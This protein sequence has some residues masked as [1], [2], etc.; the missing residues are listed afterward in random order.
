MN[1]LIRFKQVLYANWLLFFGL[2]LL[3]LLLFKN[4]F[5]GQNIIS[6]F[7]PLPDVVYYLYPAKS[8]IDGA[9]MKVIYND[10][11]LTPITPPLYT[12]IIAP[13][14]IFFNDLR[15]FY[16]INLGLVLT[17]TIFFYQIISK[18]F[19]NLA[20]K[21]IV[22]LTFIST[23]IIYWYPSFSM[24]ENLLICLFIISLWLLLKPLSGLSV[25]AAGTII[26]SFFATKYIAWPLSVSLGLF[27]FL[28]IIN[29]QK[30]DSLKVKLLM[31]LLLSTFASFLLY[32][33]LEFSTK[34]ADVWVVVLENL[35]TV[36]SAATGGRIE[37][38]DDITSQ[39]LMTNYISTLNGS[40]MYSLGDYQ[41]KFFR[42][43]AGLMGGQTP[44]AGKNLT[45][46]PV[47][48]GI[49]SLAGLFFNL[50]F[51]KQRLLACY[52]SLS[53]LGMVFFAPM[54]IDVD[55]RYMFVPIIILILSFGLFWQNI[56]SI[57]TYFQRLFYFHLLILGSLILISFN[58]YSPFKNQLKANF[59]SA[60]GS[61]YYQVASMLN[62]Y[63]KDT[64]SGQK[65]VVITILPPHVLDSYSNHNYNFLPLAKAQRF[66]QY[67]QIWN[68]T[69]NQDY[70]HLYR[71]SLTKGDAIYLLDYGIKGDFVLY[72]YYL[73]LQNDFKLNKVFSGCS[74]QCNLYKLLKD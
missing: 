69:L 13:I 46:I 37:K 4:P 30:L 66:S 61:A 48:V 35:K 62:D 26:V 3:S 22:F 56:Q 27:F 65:P 71:I 38:G 64:P 49:T 1:I 17:S 58:I 11:T 9:G 2:M 63:F 34:G 60:E 18:I 55:A 32:S 68:L 70:F 44:V 42:Y 23:P 7:G 5:S 6:D 20:V 74:T 21:I 10:S 47:V 67:P 52:L 24:P 19:S 73:R 72:Q 12:L 28:K 15:A 39:K 45:L 53:A 33:F 50:C 8:L 54:F 29:F 14:Y 25:T 40:S 36:L 41:D 43:I 31:I 59:I 16:F 51:P 57:L